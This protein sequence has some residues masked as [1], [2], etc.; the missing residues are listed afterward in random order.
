MVAKPHMVATKKETEN[1]SLQRDMTNK[2]PTGEKQHE[3]L[4]I[5]YY[6]NGEIIAQ[7]LTENKE[8]TLQA[9]FEENGDLRLAADTIKLKGSDLAHRLLRD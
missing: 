4:V 1:D 7:V 5:T 2:S 8:E 6:R 3:G 9:A